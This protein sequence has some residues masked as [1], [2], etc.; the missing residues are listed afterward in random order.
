MADV[1]DRTWTLLLKRLDAIDQR[2]DAHGHKLDAIHEETKH[3]NG[4]VT[5]EEG[6]LER[7]KDAFAKHLKD[8]SDQAKGIREAVWH[9]RHILSRLAV[10][11]VSGC[12]LI[13]ALVEL[14]AKV[15]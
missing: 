10:P 3:T 4:R 13:L 5:R 12:A 1:D 11:V 14:L 2:L 9:R 8:H 15:H 7:L 6:A